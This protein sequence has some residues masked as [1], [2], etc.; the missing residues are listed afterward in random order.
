MRPSI[1]HSYPVLQLRGKSIVQY[2]E[3]AFER[4]G[5][6]VLS[7]S[8]H[9]KSVR[10]S[11][12]AY[13]GVM[14]VGAKKR[15]TKAVSLLVQSSP[16]KNIYNEVSRSYHQFKLSF[17]TLTIPL[18]QV[19]PEAK[20]TN[21]NLL[22]PMIRVLR[23]RYG[24]KNY[25]WK[26]ELQQNK[27]IHYHLT[28]N[29]FINHSKLKDEWNKILEKNGMLNDYRSRT[30][31]KFPNSTDVKSVKHIKNF[32]AYLVKYISKSEQNQSAVNGKIWDCNKS[33]KASDYY[34][35]NASYTYQQRLEDLID[36]KKIS[37]FSSDRYIIYDFKSISVKEFLDSDDL[38]FY[39]LHLKNINNGKEARQD[40]TPPTIRT[41]NYNST[42]QRQDSTGNKALVGL[43]DI[44]KQI[45]RIQE[46]VKCIQLGLHFTDIKVL[47]NKNEQSKGSYFLN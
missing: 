17:L 29:L 13:S 47:R 9:L 8:N 27:M 45:D 6:S 2:Y 35:I 32:E 7:L 3:Y 12:P 22:E 21:K 38:V 19:K 37:Y 41:Q 36:K 18:C 30:G 25:I 23:N 20:F 26:L 14:T 4:S 28:T 1:N 42:T 15:L 39:N 11:S 43:H 34:S 24:L 40:L 46:S 10:E 5:K 16:T 44:E 33:L 31:N